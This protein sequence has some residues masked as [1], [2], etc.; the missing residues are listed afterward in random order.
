MSDETRVVFRHCALCGLEW[1]VVDYDVEGAG[2]SRVNQICGEVVVGMT[3]ICSVG[4]AV[5]RAV[6][7]I[8]L[9]RSSSPTGRMM[10]LRSITAKTGHI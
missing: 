2:A 4:C 10:G 5:L 1:I 8:K 9:F 7:N 3:V 6:A